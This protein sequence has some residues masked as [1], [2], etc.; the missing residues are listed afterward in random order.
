MTNKKRFVSKYN[1][2]AL[3]LNLTRSRWRLPNLSKTTSCNRTGTHHTI[4]IVPSTRRSVCCKTSAPSTTWHVIRWKQ[5]P[6]RNT[7]SPGLPSER[8]WDAKKIIF[9]TISVAWNSRFVAF[10][11]STLNSF[12]FAFI[13][14]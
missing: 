9:C 13:W 7:R 1:N 11:Y 5:P 14:N 8:G 3:W 12:F 6:S 10:N 4:G 2:R